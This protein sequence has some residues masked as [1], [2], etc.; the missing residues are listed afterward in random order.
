[1]ADRQ[2]EWAKLVRTGWTGSGSRGVER[3]PLT[4]APPHPAWLRRCCM[5][6]ASA[7][8][9]TLHTS[10]PHPRTRRWTLRTCA[11][12]RSRSCK[13][14]QQWHRSQPQ[15][16]SVPRLVRIA[17]ATLQFDWLIVSDGDTCV[18]V[19]AL[20]RALS[21]RNRSVCSS[22]GIRCD[23]DSSACGHGH[24]TG[25]HRRFCRRDARLLR[26]QPVQAQPMAL[27]GAGYVLS[28]ALL[29]SISA[30]Q[31]PR[32]SG[33]SG[34]TA[35]MWWR[36]AC[37]RATRVG[38]AWLPGCLAMSLAT[39]QYARSSEGSGSCGSLR[40]GNLAK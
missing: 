33:T 20:K 3:A 19:G 30:S 27:G 22:W 32:A 5:T 35:A 39:L 11:C 28:R 14:G 23:P 25:R 6:A 31:W 15:N 21:A 12:G 8:T 18:D 17:N 29:H 37:G 13:R 16:D 2:S 36:R 26:A 40:A 1:M 24:C 7:G 4:L 34:A 38:L 9:P 10:S